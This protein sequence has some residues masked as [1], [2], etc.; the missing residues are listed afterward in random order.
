MYGGSANPH[1]MDIGIRKIG[2]CCAT[3]MGYGS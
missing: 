2:K 3:S 1:R